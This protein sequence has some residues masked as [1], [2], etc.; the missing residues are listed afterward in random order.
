MTP[1]E[2]ALLK[3]V[4]DAPFEDAPRLAYASYLRGLRPPDPRGDLIP[5]AIRC[6]RKKLDELTD[7]NERQS[8]IGARI[9]MRQLLMAHESEWKAPFL[10]MVDD[11]E[12]ERGLVAGIELSAE[13]LLAHGEE[14]FGMAPIVYVRITD[15]EDR[16][17]AL[18]QFEP[19]LRIRALSFERAGLTTDDVIA[20]ADCAYLR[21][22]WWLEL[23][24][25]AIEIEGVRA[26]ALSQHLT[27]LREVDLAGNPGDAHER[28]G[29]E[30]TMLANVDFPQA[31]WDLERDVGQR[32]PWLHYHQIYYTGA[33]PDRFGPPLSP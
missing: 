12:I 28:A 31:G 8:L 15:L 13:K 32:I 26:M 19:L 9:E 6:K 10:A 20:L 25:N 27:G 17:P 11:C 24:H 18:L 23:Q 1:Q 4:C 21:N 29:F 2:E 5:Y 14:L 22:V 16:L 3:A 33:L 30:Y 7:S